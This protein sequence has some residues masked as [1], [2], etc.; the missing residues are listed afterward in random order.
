[1]YD[2]QKSYIRLDTKPEIIKLKTGKIIHKNFIQNK[3]PKRFFFHKDLYTT[4]PLG[5]ENDEIE[6]FLFG[7]IDSTEGGGGRP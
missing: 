3:G 5:Q 1:M 6:K 4:N 2:T 7:K